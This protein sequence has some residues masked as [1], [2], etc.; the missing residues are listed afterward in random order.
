[1]FAL[2]REW[3][4][5]AEHAALDAGDRYLADLALAHHAYLP[6]YSD[7]PSGVLDLVNPRLEQRHRATPAIA[8][9][10]SVK[11]KAHA[12]RAE[13]AAF[14]HAISRA[15]QLLEDS[16]AQLIGPGIFS[17]LPEKLAFYEAT[18]SV[19]LR[20]PDRA[21]HAADHALALYDPS[22][23]VDPALIRLDRASALVQAGEVPHACQV[24]TSA[25]LD[26][27]T[28][29][30]AGVLVRAREFDALL[31]D[32]RASGVREWREVLA[33]IRW[34]QPEFTRSL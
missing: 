2:A 21:I 13:R 9:L 18:G 27:H 23:I 19:K 16:P 20:N 8:W 5:A 4:Q 7:D 17:F 29:H 32:G 22:D 3:Y 25:V 31:D 34:P 33:A 1:L 30:T 10:W 14:E 12:A 26:P 24:A 28:C 11:G 15:R 6:T